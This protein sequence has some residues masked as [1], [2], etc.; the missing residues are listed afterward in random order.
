MADKV[1]ELPNDKTQIKSAVPPL[2]KI[3]GLAKKEADKSESTELKRQES[4][5]KRQ[6]SKMMETR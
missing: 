4:N 6:E 3:D 2:S 1:G 5:L